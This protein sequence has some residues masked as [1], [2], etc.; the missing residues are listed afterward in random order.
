M[1]SRTTSEAS[2]GALFRKLVAVRTRLQLKRLTIALPWSLAFGASVF[3]VA[4]GLGRPAV[5]AIVLALLA[6][7]ACTAASLVLWQHLRP[8][9]PSRVARI[10]DRR[11]GLHELLA[12]T[13]EVGSTTNVVAAALHRSADT[14]AATIDVSSVEP[15][16]WPI[17]ASVVAFFAVMLGALSMAFLGGERT[18]QAVAQPISPVT[19]A[20][21][22]ALA[23]L[24]RDAAE[25]RT[26]QHLAAVAGALEELAA[27]SGARQEAHI[28][29]TKRLAELLRSLDRIT[30]PAGYLGNRSTVAS[31]LDTASDSGVAEMMQA[32]ELRLAPL[33]VG[34]SDPDVFD[35][36]TTWLPGDQMRQEP[37]LGDGGATNR[38]EG[39][40]EARYVSVDSVDGQ[41]SQT[42]DAATAEIDSAAI[43]GA[44]K[45]ATTGAS[46]LAGL[47]TQDLFGNVDEIATP[48]DTDTISLS[49]Q[50]TEG[51]RVAVELSPDAVDAQLAGGTGT[52]GDWRHAD[53]PQLALNDLPILYRPVAGD[54]FLPSQETVS[55]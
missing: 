29:D 38:P 54:Y 40:V 43:I 30:A 25:Q 49:G 37:I 16:R 17:G 6:T 1:T 35:I 28:S 11:L 4:V 2:D 18:V 21:V 26:D 8:L 9:S 47:G 15:L 46:E 36:E 41:P 22:S 20:E 44:S 23:A 7:L 10:V 32:L 14:H 33:P 13:L 34:Q 53:L 51:R 48:A 5:D 52:V 12:T 24:V 45:D 3:G 19:A 31:P 42:D 50:E 27:E 39:P 55:R